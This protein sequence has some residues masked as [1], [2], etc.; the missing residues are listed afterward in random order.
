MIFLPL[1]DGCKLYDAS[2]ELPVVDKTVTLMIKYDFFSRG[3]KFSS[4]SQIH[5]T[6]LLP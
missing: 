6:A 4:I 3:H 5:I 1:V 2:V